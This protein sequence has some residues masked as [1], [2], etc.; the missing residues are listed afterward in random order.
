MEVCM[1]VPWEAKWLAWGVFKTIFCLSLIHRSSDNWKVLKELEK[2]AMVYW[3]A[4]DR[5]PPRVF[6]SFPVFMNMNSL[7]VTL[8]FLVVYI[9]WIHLDCL[10]A[11]GQDRHQHWK[12]FGICSSG[13]RMSSNFVLTRKQDIIQGE[14]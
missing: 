14:R 4:K 6:Q 5:L 12:R 8:R 9:Q 2:A 13:Q 3:S 11:D 10:K 1:F 7:D